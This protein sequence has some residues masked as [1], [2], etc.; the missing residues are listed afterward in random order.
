MVFLTLRK[1]KARPERKLLAFTL[2]RCYLFREL[3]LLML[4]IAS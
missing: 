1:N 4:Q 3:H 2:T